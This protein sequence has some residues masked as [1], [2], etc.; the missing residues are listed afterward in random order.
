MVEV[1]EDVVCAVVGRE[2]DFDLVAEA[3]VVAVLEEEG[4]A[5][6]GDEVNDSVEETPDLYSAFA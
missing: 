1:M 6:F 3:G 4:G 5:G 2:E